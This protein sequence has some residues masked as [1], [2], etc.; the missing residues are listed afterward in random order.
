MIQSYKLNYTNSNSSIKQTNDVLLFPWFFLR[1]LREIWRYSAWLKSNDQ[2]LFVQTIRHN[3]K[4]SL[5]FFEWGPKPAKS[6]PVVNKTTFV[7][8]G[9]TQSDTRCG[10]QRTCTHQR[11]GASTSTT[12]TPVTDTAVPSNSRG[13]STESRRRERMKEK[14]EREKEREPHTKADFTPSPPSLTQ[15]RIITRAHGLGRG[16]LAG[17]REWERERC[18]NPAAGRR[19]VEKESSNGGRSGRE[20]ERR[21]Y[22]HTREPSVGS[23]CTKSRLRRAAAHHRLHR[24]S[25]S[26][27]ETPGFERTRSER[28]ARSASRAGRF[29]RVSSFTEVACIFDVGRDR[30]GSNAAC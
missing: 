18:C 1:I 5:R 6:F 10:Y 15:S 11:P 8:T 25:L 9:Q 3:L 14:K 7:R 23:C 19:R 4:T 20:K 17:T 21:R 28:D 16:R 29:A 12:V 24:A 22:L 27:G 13:V 2:L 30:G 26:R